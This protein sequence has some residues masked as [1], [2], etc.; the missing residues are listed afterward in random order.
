LL[1]PLVN[2]HVL[3]DLLRTEMDRRASIARADSARFAAG[4][5]RRAADLAGALGRHGAQLV[6]GSLFDRRREQQAQLRA[7]AIAGWQAHLARR[8]NGASALTQIETT[9]PRFVAAWLW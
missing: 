8:M 2:H 9:T 7:D 4:I 1:L 5:Q 3:Q 6:Q